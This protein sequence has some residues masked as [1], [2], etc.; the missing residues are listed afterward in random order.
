M[1]VS[2]NISRRKKTYENRVKIG[3]NEVAIFVQWYEKIDLNASALKYRVSRT[4]HMPQVQ[5]NFY[6]V[7]AGFEM[8]EKN[9]RTNI[10]PRLRSAA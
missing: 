2:Q 7:Y 1:C 3:A 9:G 6:L 8:S 5:S 10:L 4:I